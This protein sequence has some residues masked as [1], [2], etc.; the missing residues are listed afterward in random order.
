MSAAA[1]STRRA[2]RAVFLSGPTASGKTEIALRL[3]RRFPVDLI[4]V[5]AAQVYRGMDVGTA[6][7]DRA[8]RARAPHA[9]IDIRDPEE[10]YSAAEFR[11]DASREIERAFAR[12]RLPVLVGGAMFYFAAL[13]R[14]LSALP[15]ADEETRARILRWAERDG[16][17]ALHAYL[18]EIDPR[19]AQELHAHDRQRLQRALEI[20][21]LTGRPPS[22]AM[23]ESAA[24]P[25]P[26]SFL[27]LS[28]FWPDRAQLHRR[29]GARFED[30]LHRG[31]VEEV[32]AL[33]R[34]PGVER[35]SVAMRAVGYRQVWDWLEGDIDRQAM[36]QNALAATRQLAKRQLTWLRHAPGVVWLD[37]THKSVFEHLARYVEDTV[38]D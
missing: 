37:A 12:G 15:A 17:R 10:G 30:M 8:T 16:W 26:W 14:G 33:R 28:L 31:L 29:I 7:P 18:A 2:R 34:R 9:L 21:R 25:C 23:A 38:F 11:V 4:S 36:T 19:L 20:H 35:R 24:K 27:R 22:E 6:K 5:D 3:A 13:A 32:E 1:A